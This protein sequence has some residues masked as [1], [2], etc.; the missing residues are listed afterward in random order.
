MIQENWGYI[1]P[2][3]AHE[4]RRSYATKAIE[5]DD[6]IPEAHV[7]LASILSSIEWDWE[8]AEREFKRAI[9]LNPN[10]ATAH[11]WYA[12]S[13]LGLSGR[14]DEAI[15][16]LREAMRLDPLSPIISANLGDQ[17][18]EAGRYREAE[19]QYRSVLET[20]PDFA[21]AHAHLG[22]ALLKESRYEEAISEVRK[23]VDL[24][25]SGPVVPDLIYAY[26]TV[27]REED[28]VRLLEQL[29]QDS[30]REYVSNVA[31][32]MANGAAGRKERAIELL[33]KA[34]VERSNQ[35]RINMVEPHFDQLRSDPR[36]QSLQKTLGLKTE[37]YPA[38]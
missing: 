27:G 28:A 10:Y 35:L 13:I 29:E 18:L 36:F 2:A 5:L 14:Y 9:E 24:D 32:A 17:L 38:D 12:N 26:R 11:H 21:Y 22:L 30:A 3:N 25:R 23:S 33:Q 16:E 31:L 34:A 37:N 20:A 19:E 6:S 15:R 8:G 7:A 1:S 4:K